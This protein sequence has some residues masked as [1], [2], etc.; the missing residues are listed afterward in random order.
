MI[1]SSPEVQLAALPFLAKLFISFI[2][3][4]IISSL[5]RRKP[6]PLK[7]PKESEVKFTTA[8]ASRS[9]PLLFG[10]M[11]QPAPNVIAAGDYA[12]TDVVESSTTVGHNILYGLQYALC[13]GPIDGITAIYSDKRQ[14]WP[15][16]ARTKSA[17]TA[18]ITATADPVGV[19]LD[20]VVP[21]NQTA[22]Y[23]LTFASCSESV[24]VGPTYTMFRPTRRINGASDTVAEGHNR[25]LRNRGLTTSPR[26]RFTRYGNGGYYPAG[27]L[28]NVSSPGAISFDSDLIPAGATQVSFRLYAI[29]PYGIR[30]S[31]TITFDVE[32]VGDFSFATAADPVPHIDNFQISSG[33]MQNGLD[34]TATTFKPAVTTSNPGATTSA[35]QTMIRPGDTV[36]IRDRA[37]HDGDATAGGQGGIEL[38]LTLSDGDDNESALTPYTTGIEGD[39]GYEPSDRPAPYSSAASGYPGIVTLTPTLRHNYYGRSNILPQ[40]TA[41]VQRIP[42][43]FNLPDATVKVNGVDANPAL[44]LYECLTDTEWGLGVPHGRIDDAAFISAAQTLATEGHGYSRMVQEQTSVDDLMAEIEAEIDGLVY[45]DST[46]RWTIRLIRDD[47]A[48]DDLVVIDDSN[49]LGIQDLERKTYE[50]PTNSVTVSYSDRGRDYENNDVTAFDQASLQESGLE[51]RNSRQTLAGVTNEALAVSIANRMVRQLSTPQATMRLTVDRSLWHL[52]P[53]QPVLVRTAQLG[54]DEMVMRVTK[55]NLGRPGSDSL[56]LTLTEDVFSSPSQESLIP[57]TGSVNGDFGDA[58]SALDADQQVAIEAPRRLVDLSG[59]TYNTAHRVAVAGGQISQMTS[60]RVDVDG[61]IDRTVLFVSYPAKLAKGLGRE[62]GTATPSIALVADD[63]P[64]VAAMFKPSPDAEALDNLILVGDELMLVS[65]AHLS[66]DE[67]VLSTVYRGVLDTAQTTH[68]AGT[69]VFVLKPTSS[70]LAEQFSVGDS[71][72]IDL[73]PRFGAA[74]VSA[75]DAIDM[76]LTVGDRYNKPYPPS[77]ILVNGEPWAE[78]A[79]FSD[80]DETTGLTVGLIRRSWRCTSFLDALDTD[81]EDLDSG[82]LA[83]DSTSHTVRVYVIDPVTNERAAN[84]ALLWTGDTTDAQIDFPQAYALMGEATD[85][86]G[87][88][89][90]SHVSA[91]FEVEVQARHI[92]GQDAKDAD[93]VLTHRFTGDPATEDLERITV[94]QGTEV[95]SFTASTTGTLDLLLPYGALGQNLEAQVAGGGYSVVVTQ[96]TTSGTL[97]VTAGQQVDMRFTAAPTRVNSQVQVPALVSVKYTDPDITPEGYAIWRPS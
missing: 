24:Q 94:A 49:I 32:Q 37:F 22:Y 33:G 18:D 59:A 3:S 31:A 1:E 23:R 87:G 71:P 25:N 60:L 10:T 90:D 42:R 78:A 51:E 88:A 85:A 6:D 84:N 11:R 72:V 97:A 79:A 69:P 4:T 74:T 57:A 61:G 40:I 86:L 83:A 70:I 34:Y 29:G 76:T 73:R 77:R 13:Q 7:A 27:G 16:N 62:T 44:C 75:G 30:R 15:Y 48:K 46:G 54:L 50:D 81:A 28:G 52:E 92:Q 2:L 58:I 9:I 12:T 21:A 20:E 17:P 63:A 82:Y 89:V 19:V 38:L 65:S 91:T 55:L 66:G 36:Y 56:A 95:V 26:V 43:F 64:S 45:L 80:L 68:A 8:E 39:T 93:Q 41:E 67:V 47:Y 96:S 5:V 53:G 14:V 35:D